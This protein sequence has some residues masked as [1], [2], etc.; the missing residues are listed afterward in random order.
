MFFFLFFIFYAMQVYYISRNYNNYNIKP[1][2]PLYI[3]HTR[4]YAL[5]NEIAY[6]FTNVFFYLR[7]T[8]KSDPIL[9]LSEWRHQTR[10]RKKKTTYT[11]LLYNVQNLI[12][13]IKNINLFFYT[14]FFLFDELY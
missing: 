5:F 13:V 11:Y 7:N 2:N 1:N 10:K 12:L 14:I 8:L 3:L 4:Q 6:L 9:A